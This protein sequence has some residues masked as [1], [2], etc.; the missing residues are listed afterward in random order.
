MFDCLR[1]WGRK[2]REGKKSEIL[3]ICFRELAIISAGISF[4]ENGQNDTK[5]S[6]SS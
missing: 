6:F 1:V 3:E 5:L 4:Y 2:F